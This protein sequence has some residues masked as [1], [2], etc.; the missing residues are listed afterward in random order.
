MDCNAYYV[1]T[2][3]LYSDAAHYQYPHMFVL[4]LRL[5]I[6]PTSLQSRAEAQTRLDEL[7]RQRHQQVRSSRTLYVSNECFWQALQCFPAVAEDTTHC[8]VVCKSGLQ[9]CTSGGLLLST[10][11]LWRKPTAGLPQWLRQPLLDLLTTHP[12]SRR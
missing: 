3:L 8:K 10:R 11:R 6:T 7:K 9:R 12:N 4:P 2:V 5:G 1:I